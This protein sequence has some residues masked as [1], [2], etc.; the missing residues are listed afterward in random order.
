M[1]RR[2]FRQYPN[3]VFVESGSYR[4]DGIQEALQCGF[5]RVIS[6]EVAPHLYQHCQQRFK[7]DPRVTLL[8][9]SS[10]TMGPDLQAINDRI[11]FW[12]DGHYSGGETHYV[13]TKCPLLQELDIIAQHPRHDHTL[14]IDDV[15]LL[16]TDEFEYITLES[17][18]KR[19][20]DINP[21]Y[22]I[23]FVPG[24]QDRDILV[25]QVKPT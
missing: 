6:Y 11:T 8:P 14:L 17:V 3:K 9:R 22:E 1:A 16:G 19:I 18:K 15:R 7:N 21:A 5:E 2:P 4:G 12:L 13:N 25:A 20:L 23:T 24:Y 10:V